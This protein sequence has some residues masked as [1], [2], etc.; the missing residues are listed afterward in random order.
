M[1]FG[2]GLILPSTAAETWNPNDKSTNIQLSGGNLIVG[3]TQVNDAG[4]RALFGSTSGKFYYEVLLGGS[5]V[6][7]GDALIGIVREDQDLALVGNLSPNALTVEPANGD[8]WNNGSAFAL[9]TAFVVGDT[10][11]IAA[12]LNNKTGWIR[13]NNGLW[14][15]N[16]AADP[17]T[18][19]GGQDIS[20]WFTTGHKVFPLAAPSGS[21][22]ISYITAFSAASFSFTV[23]SG[24]SPWPGS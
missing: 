12:D 13:K 22:G 7:G 23:P 1:R 20:A 11:C 5:S 18:N 3:L 15:G 16:A 17:S 2:G 14:L 24:F 6:G 8:I 9:L 19:T 4:V 10:A 21:L